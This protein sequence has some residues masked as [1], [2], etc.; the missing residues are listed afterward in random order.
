MALYTASMS[1]RDG[2]FMVEVHRLVYER[3]SVIYREVCRVMV[4][5]V[6]TC[7]AARW[8]LWATGSLLSLF[9]SF[10]RYPPAIDAVTADLVVCG[11]LLGRSGSTFGF[12]PVCACRKRPGEF[13]RG[14]RKLTM[15]PQALPDAVLLVCP[16]VGMIPVTK[17][18]LP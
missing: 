1:I 7:G 12:N 8:T 16:S 13:R 15:S 17:T 9:T 18:L 5:Q 14:M 3:F 10:W 6:E 11:L 2:G 4:P